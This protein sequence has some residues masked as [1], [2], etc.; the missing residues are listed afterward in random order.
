MPIIATTDLVMM[1]ALAALLVVG[2]R[3]ANSRRFIKRL[4]S[5]MLSAVGLFGLIISVSLVVLR[6]LRVVA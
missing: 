2:Q 6:A 3:L 1:V 5:S 4:L